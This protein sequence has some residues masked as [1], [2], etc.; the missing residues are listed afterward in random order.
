MWP[1]RQ[2]QALCLSC[3]LSWGLAAVTLRQPP[4]RTCPVTALSLNI[5]FFLFHFTL[6]CFPQ[7]GRGESYVKSQLIALFLDKS[8]QESSQ[9]SGWLPSAEAALSQ[10]IAGGRNL[11]LTVDARKEWRKEGKKGKTLFLSSHLQCWIPD[12]SVSALFYSCSCFLASTTFSTFCIYRKIFIRTFFSFVFSRLRNLFLLAF[13]VGTILQLLQLAVFLS[14]KSMVL[15]NIHL[16]SSKDL[17]YP[18]SHCTAD[19]FM[20]CLCCFIPS[21]QVSRPLDFPG[22]HERL[23]KRW[24]VTEW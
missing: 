14:L 15:M 19:L 7:K 1:K 11:S 5:A 4:L 24:G 13:L 3:K 23:S 9:K 18:E 20:S 2:V 10:W 17:P 12:I 21:K 8:A 16:A 22:D 6:L